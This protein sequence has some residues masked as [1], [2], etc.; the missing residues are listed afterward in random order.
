M[1][2]RGSRSA[3]DCMWL[4]ANQEGEEGGGEDKEEIRELRVSLYL[5]QW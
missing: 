1:Q 5:I 2:G 3:S 4:A